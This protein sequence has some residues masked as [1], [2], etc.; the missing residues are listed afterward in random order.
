MSTTLLI[1]NVFITLAL[2]FYTVGVWAERIVR[3][4]KPWHVVMF[5]LGLACD[6]VGTYA[7]ERLEP[8]IDWLSVHTITGQ[9]AIWLMFG[10]AIWATWTIRR[11][12]PEAQ[13]RFYKYSIFVW[14]FWLVPYIGGAV[15][16]IF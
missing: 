15:F 2:V 14:L 12:T 16:G 4:L 3:L 13:R 1:A 5:W 10:H 9:L 6:A 8:G 7:M 11:G